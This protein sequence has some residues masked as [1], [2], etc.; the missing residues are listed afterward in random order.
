[1][2]ND[3]YTEQRNVNTKTG[4]NWAIKQLRQSQPYLRSDIVLEARCEVFT[5]LGQGLSHLSPGSN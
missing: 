3:S 4:R 1:M 2:L 5:L